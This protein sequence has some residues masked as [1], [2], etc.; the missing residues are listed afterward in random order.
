MIRLATKIKGLPYVRRHAPTIRRGLGS[1]EVC[2]I[3][4]GTYI[5]LN[6]S[7]LTLL[8]AWGADIGRNTAV[9]HGLQ[10]RAASRLTVGEDVFIAENVILDARGSLHI[11]S[12]VSINSCAQIWTAQHAWNLEG[13]PYVESPVRVGSFTWISA[14]SIILPG[15]S[16]GEGAVVAAGSVV[17]GDVPAWCLYAGNPA[18]KVRDRSKLEPYEL[19]ARRNKIWWW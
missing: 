12:H 15:V 18:R 8:R 13:F 2:S 6:S 10:V 9:H 17:T 16:I 11:G 4:L 5:P 19:D 3:S 1:V 7:R 14:G